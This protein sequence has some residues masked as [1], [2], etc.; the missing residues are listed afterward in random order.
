MDRGTL[1]DLISKVGK[2]PEEELGRMSFDLLTGLN[3][4]HKKLHTIHRDLKPQN[5]LINSSGEI[6]I[7]DF[8]VSGEIA[9]TAA[10]ANTFVGTIKYMSVRPLLIRIRFSNRCHLRIIKKNK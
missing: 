2:V 8:G 7:T 5:I 4:L 1:A 3:Y 9:N 10:F 6:K